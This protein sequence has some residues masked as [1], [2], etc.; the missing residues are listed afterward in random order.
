M[1]FVL[2]NAVVYDGTGGPARHVDVG[3]DGDRIVAVGDV[4]RASAED[5][6]TEV[7]DLEGR[8]LSPG[9]VDAHTHFDAQVTWDPA[10]TP[11][12]WH[13]VTT[14]VMGNCGFGI[15]P[16]REE[17][18]RSIMRTLENVEGMSFDALDAGIAWSFESFP[19][20]LD[21]IDRQPIRLNVAALIGHTP[22]RVHVMREAATER[23]A[24]PDEISEMCTLLGDALR[25]GAVGFA[26]SKAGVHA[27]EDGKPVPS[28]FAE[29]DEITALTD[30]LR[31]EQRG[32]LQVTR[33]P[34][35]QAEDL[36]AISRRTGRPAT[37]T[38]LVTS[39]HPRGFATELLDRTEALGG[40]VWPQIACQ[41]IVQQITIE[42]P[43]PL[44]YAD[45]IRELL[46]VPR[47]QRKDLCRDRA[48]RARARADLEDPTRH[49]GG[50]GAAFW[51]RVGIDESVAHA[52]LVGANLAELARARGIDPFDL[53]VDL[54]LDEDLR[55][56]FR[57]V[58]TN[59]DDDEIATL[60]ND[61]RALLA[62][63]DAGAHVSQLCDASFSTRLL[64]TWV[65]EREAISLEFA[66]WRLTAHPAQ[67]FRIPDRGVI[68]P[69][70]WADL[71]A[72]DPATI[73]PTPN[74]RVADLPGGADRLLSHSV[75]IDSVW[76]NGVATVRD[77]EDVD[78]GGSGQLLRDVG[79]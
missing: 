16:T 30:V 23:A 13:G 7:I 49:P 51:D 72:F 17:H 60:L 22:L 3:V 71:V 48:W 59:Y 47:E 38:A 40:E 21:A 12:C 54:S 34:G 58:M 69:G 43:G 55:T 32:I 68:R 29:S 52:D 73:A 10:L 64:S 79:V 28:R 77:G 25:A 42:E 36:A 57:C 19:E 35:L 37:W 24:T 1:N 53:M 39:Q 31:E 15:A 65:R 75:G 44:A 4:S 63:S 8:A 5:A 20:Y 61:R 6:G 11:S 46:A 33:G 56:R 41:P 18:R 26:T 45:A 74:Q 67:V 9:F 78:S 2:R 70:A 76:V 27:G 62:V 50:G 14:V 66:I